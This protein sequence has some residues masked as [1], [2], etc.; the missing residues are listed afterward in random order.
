MA[1]WTGQMPDRMTDDLY[2]RA[3]SLPWGKRENHG[4]VLVV[5]PLPCRA[6]SSGT[7]HHDPCNSLFGRGSPNSAPESRFM[8]LSCRLCIEMALL[9]WLRCPFCA[10]EAYAISTDGEQVGASTGI[11]VWADCDHSP[12]K[13]D[14]VSFDELLPAV[15]CPECDSGETSL[16][17]GIRSFGEGGRRETIS[18]ACEDDHE[19]VSELFVEELDPLEVEWGSDPQT[20]L[21]GN[22]E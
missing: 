15:V 10:S 9:D 13:E 11:A 6:C 4:I 18:A 16:D 12:I 8:S 5:A 1:T 14:F 7:G 2:A 3:V 21:S 22:W 19:V 20:T 17:H